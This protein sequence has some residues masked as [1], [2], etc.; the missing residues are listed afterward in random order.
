MS[1]IKVGDKVASLP[2]AFIQI[3]GKVVCLHPANSRSVASASVYDGG[4][5]SVRVPLADLR[6]L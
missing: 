4:Y 6:K 1:N 5:A 3:V 2:H